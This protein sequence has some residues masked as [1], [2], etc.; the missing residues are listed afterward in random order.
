MKLII[1]EKPSLARNIAAGIGSMSRG[2][3]FL[4]GQDYIISWAFGHLFTLCDIEDYII[5]DGTGTETVPAKRKWSMDGLPCFPDK[6][7]FKLRPGDDGKPDAG[8]LKQFN[9]IKA[10]C[11]RD[12]VECVVNA[13]D[14]DRE[15]EIIVRLCIEN[16]FEGTGKV[17]PVYRLWL[18]DQTP[19]TVKAAIEQMKSD[20]EYDSLAREG[21]ARTYTDWLYGVNLTRY[22]T[23]K[24]GVFLRC[25]RVIIPIVKAIYDRDMLIKNFVPEKYFAVISKTEQGGVEVELV[26]KN[27]FSADKQKQ[28][29]ELCK[30]YNEAKTVVTSVKSK[31]ETV[32]PGKLY[33]LSKLQSVLGKKFKM[34]MNESLAAAQK[35]YEEG[36]ITY[37]RT[38]S[39]YLATNEKDRIKSIIATVA[40]LGYPVEFKDTKTIFDDSKIE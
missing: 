13:G 14:S 23:I 15:G 28:A 37:P 33:S 39:E 22:A 38:N 20:A 12:D 9:T 34:P 19:Q 5:N 10:L 6:F 16:A 1:A 2:D 32:N 24:T 18:P 21:F 3:G 26:S 31:K 30:K 35:L 29:E 7:R 17:K 11:L 8:I 40:K 25:G 27:K 36:Y 4:Y